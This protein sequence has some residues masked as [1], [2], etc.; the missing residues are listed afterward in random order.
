M[1]AQAGR[2]ERMA[3]KKSEQEKASR[4][5]KYILYV[6]LPPALGQAFEA[7]LA[8]TRPRT[9]KSAAAEVAMEDFLA[10]RGFWPW[11]KEAE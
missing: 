3:K 2:I 11:P 9:D 8:S 4:A 6:T 10:P 1:I 5:K 7:Y